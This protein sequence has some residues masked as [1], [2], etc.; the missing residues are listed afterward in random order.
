MKVLFV[1]PEQPNAKNGRSYQFIKSLSAQGHAVSLVCQSARDAETDLA[2]SADLASLCADV[3]VVPFSRSEALVQCAKHFASSIPLWPASHFSSA[4]E[5]TIDQL[6]TD[7]VFDVAHVSDLRCANFGRRINGRVPVI[8]DTEHCISEIDA[9]LMD[10]SSGSSLGQFFTRQEQSKLSRYEP[11]V[12]SMFD[13]VIT[14]TSADKLALRTLGTNIG[15]NLNIDVVPNGVDMEVYSPQDT[16]LFAGQIVLSGKL[17][18]EANRDASYYFASE[19]FPGIRQTHPRSYMTF[20]GPVY[21]DGSKYTVPTGPGIEVLENVADIRLPFSTASV[22]ACP[23]RV[24][25]GHKTNILE[26]MAMSKAVVSSPIGTRSLHRPKI[27][28]CILVAD[29]PLSFATQ[30]VHLLSHPEEVARLGQNAHNFV[31]Q[32]HDWVV[33]G[34]RLVRIYEEV[35]EQDKKQAAAS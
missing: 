22:V 18:Y 1:A 19:I 31:K 17:H 7:E 25:V 32:N 8:Y 30:I 13:R 10:G 26:A 23:V 24:G 16:P 34:Q 29:T 12:A 6:I 5:S 3:H 2:V 27:G 4:L 9:Q 33:V 35:I 15:A 20:V 11:K 14:S 28:E 21:M